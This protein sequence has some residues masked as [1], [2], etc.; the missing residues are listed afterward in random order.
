M[1]SM[2]IDR[3]GTSTAAY[4]AVE[5]DARFPGRAV[6]SS[7]GRS[8]V[9]IRRRRLRFQKSERRAQGQTLGPV[10]RTCVSRHRWRTPTR[11]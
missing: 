2:Y 5:P 11:C 4:V 10:T 6:S 1:A 7:S 9:P 8:D 3:M